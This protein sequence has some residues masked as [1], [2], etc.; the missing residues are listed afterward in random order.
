MSIQFIYFDL[1]RVLLDFTYQRGFDQIATAGNVSADRVREILIDE[2]LGQRCERGEL[3]NR[4]AAPG[5]LQ[6]GQ[7]VDCD[8]G[9]EPRLERYI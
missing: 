2:G 7:H 5:V 8:G 3:S 6:V 4:R 9:S 1:G